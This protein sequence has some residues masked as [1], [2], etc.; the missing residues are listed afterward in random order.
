M[1]AKELEAV[2]KSCVGYGFCYSY[3]YKKFITVYFLMQILFHFRLNISNLCDQIK[4][5]VNGSIENSL[6]KTTQKLMTLE[7]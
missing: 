1:P 3:L 7:R 5:R 2:L 4:I 6:F